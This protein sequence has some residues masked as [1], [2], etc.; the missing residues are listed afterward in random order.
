MKTT[1]AKLEDKTV[2]PTSTT[3]NHPVSVQSTSQDHL[4]PKIHL[5][6]KLPLSLPHKNLSID[7]TTKLLCVIHSTYLPS[8]LTPPR[9]LYLNNTR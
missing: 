2:I 3:G 9:F 6:V 5:Y 7:L 1:V 8:P 4:S